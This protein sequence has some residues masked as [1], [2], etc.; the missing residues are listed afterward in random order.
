MGAST[1]YSYYQ[2]RN[3][4]IPCHLL[5]ACQGNNI[6]EKVRLAKTSFF[7]LYMTK[8]CKIVSKCSQNS[9]NDDSLAQ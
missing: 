3:I 5:I 6:A 1:E 2:I 7:I 9:D 8:Q 4:E